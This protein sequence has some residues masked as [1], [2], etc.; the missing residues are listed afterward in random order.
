[1]CPVLVEVEV[2]P[3][4]RTMTCIPGTADCVLCA[5]ATGIE[6]GTWSVG[7]WGMPLTSHIARECDLSV[8]G[9]DV[10]PYTVFRASV[11][12]VADAIGVVT[13]EWSFEDSMIFVN[14]YGYYNRDKRK[15][16]RALRRAARKVARNR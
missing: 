8:L 3:S 9:T 10:S 16:V 5:V 13:S 6:N 14:D 7:L 15:T 2:E 12:A 1:M 4:M 11:L